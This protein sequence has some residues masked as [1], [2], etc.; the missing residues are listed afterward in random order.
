MTDQIHTLKTEWT[1]LKD[2]WFQGETVDPV[3]EGVVRDF[4]LFD[5]AM[6]GV[7]VK[8]GAFMKGVD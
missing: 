3:F 1:A 5:D 8:V 2:K 4:C 6:H 7:Q